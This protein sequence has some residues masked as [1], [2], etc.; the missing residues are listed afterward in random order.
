MNIG[1]KLAIAAGGVLIGLRAAYPVKYS[2]I[3]S[4]RFEDGPE[5]LQQ[6]D[7]RM[8]W[9]HIAGIAAVTIALAF[10]LKANKNS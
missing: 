9:L 8:T 3:G 1:Q 4:L 2:G 7:W 10:I 6:V 5:F